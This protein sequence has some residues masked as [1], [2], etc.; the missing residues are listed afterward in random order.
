MSAE[1]LPADASVGVVIVNKNAGPHLG[2]VLESLE[3]QT[4]QARRVVVVDNASTDESLDGL[5]ERFPAVELVRSGENL[6]F[7]AANNLAVGMCG[8]C[9]LVAL[10]NP[11]AFPEPS[12][13]ETL[14]AAAAEHPDYGFFGSRLVRDDDV[15]TLDGTG[16]MYHVSGLAW[17]RD[18]GVA[19]TVERGEGETFSACAAAA[20]YR[21]DVFVGVGGFDETFFCYY[22]DTDLAFRLRLAGQ[23]CLYV[24]GA[25]VRHVGSATAGLMS[26]FT[27]Y[28]STRNQVWVFVKNMPRP[29]LWLYL[30]QHVFV[31][32]LTTLVYALHGQGR[33]ALRG[34]RDAMRALPR[35]LRERRRIQRGRVA[36]TR[37]VR[38]AMS[39]GVSGYVHSFRGS[40][41]LRLL[42][43]PMARRRTRDTSNVTAAAPLGETA[44]DWN[45]DESRCRGARL[46]VRRF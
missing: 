46:R 1:L 38:G 15:G 32:V 28:H 43:L 9:E 44:N 3:R 21:R 17:R 12:W 19:A 36:S 6:G 29:L 33:A 24:P 8:D 22:E 41:V 34:K 10:L 26:E 20:L 25:V 13:L 16:D 27:I 31:G 7:A 23:R 18:Q 40:W 45:L 30:P 14:V 39:R 5:E 11:D 2:R 37:D 42:R 35:V 4:V